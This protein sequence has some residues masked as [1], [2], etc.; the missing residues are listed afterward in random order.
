MIMQTNINRGL[1][2]GL[3]FRPLDNTILDVIN[4]YND[5]NGDDQEWSHGLK[6]NRE[7]EL[8]DKL[9]VEK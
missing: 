1:D 4:W 3:V 8:I 6:S 7:K 2:N 9:R 5:I